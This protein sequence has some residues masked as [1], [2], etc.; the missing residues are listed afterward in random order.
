MLNIGRALGKLRF[1][2]AVGTWQSVHSS[3]KG[4]VN[5]FA[6]GSVGV[7]GNSGDL[8]AI[9]ILAEQ[10]GR[11]VI[12]ASGFFSMTLDTHTFD[13]QI[14]DTTLGATIATITVPVAVAGEASTQ[15]LRYVYT[16]PA[17]GSRSFA[18]RV[19]GNGAALVTRSACVLSVRGVI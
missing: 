16:L 11:V 17:S 14:R 3:P 10:T 19:N 12:E 18:M 6:N 2:D 9:T 4:S 5:E 7:A 8:A 13:L 1:T 15:I